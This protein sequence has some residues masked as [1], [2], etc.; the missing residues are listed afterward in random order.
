M[1]EVFKNILGESKMKKVWL[2]VLAVL[3]SVSSVYAAENSVTLPAPQ[4]TGG[5]PLMEALSK[6]HTS[7]DFSGQE[8]DK[9]TVS[10]ILWSAF[11]INRDNGKRTIPTASN[12]QN[13]KVFALLPEGIYEYNAKENSLDLVEAVDFRAKAGK[14]TEMLASSGIVLAYV[15]KMG[16]AYNK[17]NSGEAVQNV[18]LY[19]TSA[20][21]AVVVIASANY[22]DL[23]QVLKLERGYQVQVIQALGHQK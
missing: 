14:Q 8:L 22:K 11:G 13:L 6:R 2:S 12:T 7:R 3:M 15:E 10:N 17:F 19:A 18:N 5:M 4:K 16:D 20:D 9:Q 1:I 21:L 23:A